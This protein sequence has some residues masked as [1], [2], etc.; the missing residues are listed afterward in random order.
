RLDPWL[1]DGNIILTTENKCFCVHR[2][3]LCLNSEVWKDMISLPSNSVVDAC[4]VVQ[5]HDSAEDLQIV[6]RALYNTYM[7][8][9]E[10]KMPLRIVSAFLRLGEKYRMKSL[11]DEGKA[12]L[13]AAHNLATAY[14][15]GTEDV[16]LFPK[17]SERDK[18]DFQ[19]INLAREIG[20][21]SILPVPILRCCVWC[22]LPV[23]LDGDDVD[24][25]LYR[26]HP[27]DQRICILG[28]DKLNGLQSEVT[29]WVTTEKISGCTGATTCDLNQLE[30]WEALRERGLERYPFVEWGSLTTQNR[31]IAHNNFCTRC[32]SAFQQKHKDATEKAWSK[33]PLVLGLGS[34]TEL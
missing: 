13:T 34:W 4:A 5:L 18:Y 10:Q 12:R 9:S 14:K 22:P 30:V 1:D 17:I 6:L 31:F 26:L 11:Y 25:S 21:L 20:L 32:A 19:I 7:I 16:D 33:L 24:G 3:V 27:E 29:S 2:S 23:I 15:L 28:K 8:L